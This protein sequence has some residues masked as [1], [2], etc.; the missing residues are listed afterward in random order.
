MYIYIYVCVCVSVCVCVCVYIYIH[1]I[2]MYSNSKDVCEH[3]QEKA[4]FYCK[5]GSNCMMCCAL[6]HKEAPTASRH[7]I[8]LN[9]MPEHA[10]ST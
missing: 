3:C 2:F 10:I 4:I 1:T 9:E 5:E 8:Q 6:R 7:I